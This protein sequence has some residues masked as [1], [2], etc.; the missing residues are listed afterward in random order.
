MRL[1]DWYIK[2]VIQHLEKERDYHKEQAEF[3]Q[4]LINERKRDQRHRTD[5]RFAAEVS[6]V[7]E[8]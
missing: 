1:R 7:K 3:F 6:M 2:A 5:K 8:E 4:V